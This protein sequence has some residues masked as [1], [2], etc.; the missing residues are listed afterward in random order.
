MHRLH[1]TQTGQVTHKFPIAIATLLGLLLV[2]SAST[3]L[4]QTFDPGG[5]KLM[6]VKPEH[7]PDDLAVTVWP[8]GVIDVEQTHFLNQHNLTALIVAVANPQAKNIIAAT[9]VCDLPQGVELK[10]VNANLLWNTKETI[11][12]RRDGRTYARHRIVVRWSRDTI[13]LLY[14]SPSPRDPKTSRMPSSA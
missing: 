4:A 11:P 5:L 10:A 1:R 2:A 9:L 14:T 13:C 6:K 12:V 3:T 8:T 7:K